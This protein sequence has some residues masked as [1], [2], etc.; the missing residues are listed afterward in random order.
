MFRPVIDAV[1]VIALHDYLAG[2][3]GWVTLI[4]GVIFI[5]CVLIIRARHGRRGVS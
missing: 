1:I 2:F 4:Q 5:A 3:G